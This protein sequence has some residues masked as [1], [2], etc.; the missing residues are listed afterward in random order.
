MSRLFDPPR[1]TDSRVDVPDNIRALLR[2]AQHDTPTFTQL[3]G[4]RQNLRP[5]LDAPLSPSG[6]TGP[7]N[8][9]ITGLGKLVIITM[10]VG[11]SGLAYWMYGN[12][13]AEPPMRSSSI[14]HIVKQ[15]QQAPLQNDQPAND[16][17]I[18]ANVT[19]ASMNTPA[20]ADTSLIPLRPANRISKR[21]A[22]KAEPKPVE[23]TGL[24]E[25]VA[26]TIES[27]P[28]AAAPVLIENK[29]DEMDEAR[30]LNVARNVLSTDPART[31]QLT[32]EHYRKFGTGILGE[33]RE[34]LVIEALA[35]LGHRDQAK[36]R[37]DNFLRAYPQSV[38]R[39]RLS[40]QLLDKE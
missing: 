2:S 39:T 30:L 17:S 13:F 38:Y 37:A 35:R 26:A 18:G 36:Q 28:A 32:N 20:P 6:F 12:K 34:V 25:Q 14:A 5:I 16:H 19:E 40:R 23:T 31:L 21:V 10:V 3:A 15:P 9:S 27:Q 33:E 8:G 22:S 24:S 4:L 7:I 1:L 29:Q 11:T